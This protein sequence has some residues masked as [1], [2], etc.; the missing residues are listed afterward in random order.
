MVSGF[1]SAAVTQQTTKTPGGLAMPR[2][3]PNHRARPAVAPPEVLGHTL[4]AGEADPA[5]CAG[6]WPAVPGPDCPT[7]LTEVDARTLT[8]NAG[9]VRLYLSTGSA[10]GH[11]V[12]HV[13]SEDGRILAVITTESRAEALDAYRHPFARPDVPDVF[14]E[15]A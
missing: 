12:V 4:T 13:E 9:R 6:V 14:G 7:A 11:C 2:P 1:W 10:A 15:A 3:H 8:G 5:L